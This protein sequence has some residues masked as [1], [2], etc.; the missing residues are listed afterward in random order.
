MARIPVPVLLASFL[1]LSAALQAAGPASLVADINSATAEGSSGDANIE[2]GVLA[3]GNRLLFAAREPGSGSEPWVSDGTDAGTRLLRDLCAGGCS[4]NPRLLGR[5][6]GLVVFVTQ[7][8][9]PGAGIAIELWRTDGTR[10]GT[11]ALKAPVLFECFGNETLLLPAEVG[12]VVVFV[13][14]SP[15][16]FCGL[17]RTDGTEA[18]TRRLAD[19]PFYRDRPVEE[20]PQL[21]GGKLFF[22]S[23]G[24]LW[25]TDGTEGGTVLLASLDPGDGDFFDYPRQLTPVGSRVFFIAA[26]AAG[27]G[28]ELWTSD[29]TAAGTR[30][31]T[32]FVAPS[33]FR[34]YLALKVFDGIVYF[35]ADDVTGGGDLWRSDG[36]AAGTRRV[37][38]FGFASPFGSGGEG[39]GELALGKAGNRLVFLASDGITGLRIWTSDGTPAGTAP[40]EGCPG[41]CPAVDFATRLATLGNRVLFRGFDLTAGSELWSTD[42]TA[43]GTRRLLD[44][45]PG[46]C[47]S[48][49]S[50]FVIALGRLFFLSGSSLWA[51]DGTTQGTARL[52]DLGHRPFDPPFTPPFTAVT[53]GGR[54]YFAAGD[55]N[56][57]GRQLW[58]SDGTPEGTGLVTLIGRNGPGSFPRDLT[59]FG[60][61]LLFFAHDGNARSLWRSGGTAASTVPL[62]STSLFDDVFSF[63]TLNDLT[64][65]G[66]LAF[67]L[68]GDRFRQTVQVWRTDG[69]DAGTFPVLP[70]VPPSFENLAAF[71]GGAVF[72]T[73]DASSPAGT[74]FW[75]SDGTVAGTVKLFDLQA[76]APRGLR[77]L[78]PDLY[79]LAYEDGASGNEQVWASDGTAA[80]TRKLTGFEFQTFDS[81][82]LPEMVKAGSRVYFVA[83]GGLWTTDGTAAG[84][85]P[86]VLPGIEYQDP[87]SLV[88]FQGRI[89]FMGST[90]QGTLGRGL[91]RSDGTAAGTTLVKPVAPP[92]T[93]SRPEPAWLTVLGPHLFFTADDGEHGLELWRTDG[94]T[95]GTVLV[96]DIAPGSASSFPSEL[97]AAGGR[98]FFRATNGIHGFEL[99]ESDGTSA[100]TRMVQDVSPGGL[101]SHPE[102]L[103]EAGGRLY[104]RADDGLSGTELWSL[105]LAAPPACQPSELALCLG[106][107]FRV[108]ATWRDFQGNAGR[109]HA[110]PLTGDTGYFWFF[111][112]ANVEVILKVLDGQGLNGHHWVFYGALSTVEYTLTVT[113]VQTGASRRYI[114]PSGRL[115][116]V[117]D[118]IAFGPKGATGS[119]KTLGP[120]AV[121]H[122]PITRI[123]KAAAA[124]CVPSVTRLCLQGGRF[125]VEA[126]WRD[127]EGNVGKGTAVPL[128]GGDTGYF[129]FFGPENVEVV[130]KVLDGR[131]LNGKFWVFYGALSSVQYTLTVTDT[132]TGQVKK[133]ENPSGRLGSVADTGA[134]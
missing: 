67:F 82:V 37:T 74:S 76:A 56:G 53:L 70:S 115:G 126:D 16:D 102:E 55:P 12:G 10:E 89:Y 124:P 77:A 46:L 114:N 71:Q 63:A 43:A 120:A 26:A 65:A 93:F 86:I 3:F 83:V 54:I 44:I 106:G 47:S 18:G 130:L 39:S 60:N 112:P 32:Q 52:A 48:E 110:V 33:P 78:G 29:G 119:Q 28:E 7:M 127:F 11:A 58:T 64:V 87:N 123:R 40:L 8:D 134:F 57:I 122:E 15:D 131:A 121:E 42:G 13:A 101:S 88:A 133:Y 97:A 111:D 103:T 92:Y 79:F 19:L 116:S 31:V 72:T 9:E 34:P 49:P 113:D 27:G 104:F 91:W 98:L 85:V 105:P 1:L 5:T 80:G 68:R 109:G 61:D 132:E 4:S 81:Q 50:G 99:W 30:P 69:T 66:G 14:S 94:T 73:H 38:D 45:C 35:V 24:A 6:G 90:G 59:G 41:G 2:G 128:P 17:W 62:R 129:W 25:R 84:T 51:T 23:Q 107:R 117:G 96:R 108:E 21:A 20:K 75:K 36:T 22:F 95:E 118:T 125:A 100:G